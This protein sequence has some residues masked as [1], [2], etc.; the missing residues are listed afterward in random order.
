MIKR[1]TNYL[2]VIWS[3][4]ILIIVFI[5]GDKI[6][7]QSDW[8]D[9]FQIDKVIHILLFAPFSFIW[10]LK[11]QLSKSLNS[12]TIYI[13]LLFG[14]LLAFLTEVIQYYFIR[15]RNGNIY[16][17]IADI[18]GVFLGLIVFKE[19]RKKHIWLFFS[20]F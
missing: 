15:G 14:I 20:N 4:M 10:L 2:A 13:I 5:P 17:A 11:Y 3:L 7:I 19:I 1:I 18:L 12:K 6:P 16:D 8:V 9:L